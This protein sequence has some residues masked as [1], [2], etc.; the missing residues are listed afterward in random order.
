M[1]SLSVNGNA[2]F[3]ERFGPLLPGC[4]PVPFGDAEALAREL[5]AG[6]VAALIVEP[7]QGK[8]VYLAPDGYLPPPRSCADATARC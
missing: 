5:A 1:G 2:E 3:R 6:D 7:V 8:G 4:E